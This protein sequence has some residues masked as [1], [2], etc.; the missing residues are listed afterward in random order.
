MVG[1]QGI[2]EEGIDTT[3]SLEYEHKHNHAL[4][5][6]HSLR[7]THA[8]PSGAYTEAWFT[9]HTHGGLDTITEDP[10]LALIQGRTLAQ[11]RALLA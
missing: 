7:A 9:Q 8:G 1:K 4:T 3:N 10:S 2:W 6:I 11:V 5:S